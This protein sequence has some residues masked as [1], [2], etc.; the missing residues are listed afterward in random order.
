MLECPACGGGLTIAFA[1]ATE[2][3]D[4]PIRVDYQW[5]SCERCSARYN[6]V[7]IEDKT[8]I[9]NDDLEHTG[10]ASEPAAWAASMARARACGRPRDK[11]CTCPIHRGGV[12]F[13]RGVQ[14]WYSSG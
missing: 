6:A 1:L 3:D 2:R 14:A 5:W 10:Y 12:P 8:N 11:R 4:R 13:A 7:L 9:F